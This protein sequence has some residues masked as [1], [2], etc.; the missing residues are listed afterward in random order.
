M[1][2][3][4]IIWL[5]DQPGWAYDNRATAISGLLSDFDHKIVLDPVRNYSKAIMAIASADLLIC[6]DPR[7]MAYLPMGSKT[8]LHLNAIK[9]FA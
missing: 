6:P 8:I 4:K 9:I 3:P 7:L 2:K 5:A 1:K